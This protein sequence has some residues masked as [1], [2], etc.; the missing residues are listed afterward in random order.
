MPTALLAVLYF[1]AP[2]IV[3]IDGYNTYAKLLLLGFVFAYTFLFPS[4]LVFWLYR[5]KHIK[6]MHLRS[7]SDRRIPYLFSI[8]SSGFLSVFFYQK[9]SQL[10]PSAF[11][12]G[13]IT[14]IIILVAII[15]FKWQIS[16]HSAGIGGVLG[17][18]FLLKIRYDEPSLFF[19]IM[20]TL[21]I[22][23]LV[24]TARLK[25]NAHTMAQVAA[26]FFLGL[27]VSIFG[28]IFI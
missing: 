21:L 19:P 2:Y 5:K 4:L 8:I 11:I 26:G 16:A 6:S 10:Q 14:I 12:I 20:M 22:A 1:I 13:F 9:G 3:G 24:L 18:L 7:L 15:S 23:G 25:L 27:T 28:T 17:A